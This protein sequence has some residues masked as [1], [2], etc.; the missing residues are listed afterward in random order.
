M[1]LLSYNT[2][3]RM[4]AL[5]VR[6]CDVDSVR[7]LAP[8]QPTVMPPLTGHPFITKTRSSWKNRRKQTLECF[9]GSGLVAEQHFL[10]ITSQSHSYFLKQEITSM[11]NNSLKLS[12]GSLFKPKRV[13]LLCSFEC[14]R[15]IIFY[16]YQNGENK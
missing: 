10:F 6:T 5:I 12:K 1:N 15:L 16:Q 4:N 13:Q 9:S 7:A 3:L 8:H 11:K 14:G 2:I